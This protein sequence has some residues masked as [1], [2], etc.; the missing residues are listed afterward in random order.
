LTTFVWPPRRISTTRVR[1][2]A[3][4]ALPTVATIAAS[5]SPGAEPPPAEPAPAAPPAPLS[6]APDRDAP[7]S[8]APPRSRAESLDPEVVAS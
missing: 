7:S 8:E 2:T 5:R 1:P 4:S 3:G 6:R